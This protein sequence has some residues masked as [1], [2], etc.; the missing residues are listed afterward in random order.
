[1]DQ[2]I[3]EFNTND[4]NN[5]QIVESLTISADSISKRETFITQKGNK[6]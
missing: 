2:S 6:M 4:P 3:N 1:M 5:N